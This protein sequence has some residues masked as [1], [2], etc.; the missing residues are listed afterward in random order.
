M[1]VMRK[2]EPSDAPVVPPDESQ[3]ATVVETQPPMRLLPA[4]VGVAVLWWAQAL[5]I[6]VV[7]AVLASYALEPAVKWLESIHVRRAFGVPLLL[8]A[9]LAGTANGVYA[10]AG[11]AAAFTERL[12]SAAHSIAH[13]P[14][15]SA[16]AAGRVRDRE[17]HSRRLTEA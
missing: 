3:P 10:L 2:V 12:P 17:G 9:L 4:M 11:E 15:R 5:V 8:G 16:G 1:R 14:P 7:L 6:P 13:L